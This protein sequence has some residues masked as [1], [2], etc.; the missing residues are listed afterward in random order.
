MA[1]L[2]P[3][4][5]VNYSTTARALARTPAERTQ[6]IDIVAPNIDILAKSIDIDAP[7]IEILVKSIDIDAPNIDFLA[8]RSFYLSL[9]CPV[10]VL[11]LKSVTF[12]PGKVDTGDHRESPLQ[13]LVG[14]GL[15]A[16]PRMLH[17]EP[18]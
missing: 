7:N 15:R 17:F 12:V 6:C 10:T 3:T 1:F 4:V 5:K 13:T 8:R 14:A 18:L 16:C 9:V 11:G 2:S